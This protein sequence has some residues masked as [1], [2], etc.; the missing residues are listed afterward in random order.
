MPTVN[1]TDV[2]FG[3]AGFI[4]APAKLTADVLN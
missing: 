4:S 1:V 3:T 2:F